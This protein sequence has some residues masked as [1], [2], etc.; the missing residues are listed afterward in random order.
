MKNFALLFLLLSSNILF[1][2]KE[3]NNWCFGF[4]AGLNFN[5]GSPVAFTNSIMYN[6]DGVASISD[7]NGNLLFYTNG[8]TFGIKTILLWLMVLVY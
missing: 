2:Q 3:G 1:A 8:V 7:A 4:Y 6:L 5:S